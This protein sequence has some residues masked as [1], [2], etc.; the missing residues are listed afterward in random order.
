MSKDR[1]KEYIGIVMDNKK[2]QQNETDPLFSLGKFG[3]VAGFMGMCIRVISPTSLK[4]VLRFSG[5][6]LNDIL[7]T[8]IE[9]CRF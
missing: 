8:Q 7:P 4:K 5:V 3:L 9:F 1:K 6:V 2:L